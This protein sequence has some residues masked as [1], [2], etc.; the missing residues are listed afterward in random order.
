VTIELLNGGADVRIGGTNQLTPLHLVAAYGTTGMVDTI[1]R[2]GAKLEAATGTG[3]TPLLLAA[4]YNRLDMVKD[5]LKRGA[6]T[7]ATNRAGQNALHLA[8]QEVRNGVQQIV[9]VLID[10]GAR[11]KAKDGGRMTPL[12]IVNKQAWSDSVAHVR[13]VLQDAPS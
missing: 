10:K 5:L 11:A 8:V 13:R 9:A 4:Q 3:E 1:L 7:Q 12:Q 6:S 2:K